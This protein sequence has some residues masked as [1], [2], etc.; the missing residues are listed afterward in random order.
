MGVPE[1]GLALTGGYYFWGAGV[2]PSELDPS[3]WWIGI[4]LSFILLMALASAGE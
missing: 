4:F 1:A 2:V 3:L